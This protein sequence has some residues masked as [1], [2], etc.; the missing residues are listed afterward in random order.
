MPIEFSCLSCSAPQKAADHLVGR[1]LKCYR[2][3]A[4][5]TVP[6]LAVAPPSLPES[7]AAFEI[8]TGTID[9]TQGD[10][11]VQFT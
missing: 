5:F 3:G 6:A 11:A 2:C 7:G 4:V 1:V 8:S 9:L 10:D